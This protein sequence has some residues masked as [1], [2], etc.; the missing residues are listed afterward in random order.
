MTSLRS[1]VVLSLPIN[2]SKTSLFASSNSLW[3]CSERIVNNSS[4]CESLSHSIPV[5]VVFIFLI[6]VLNVSLSIISLKSFRKLMVGSV[7]ITPLG[8]SIISHPKLFNCVKNGFSTKV[9]SLISIPL[10]L[11]SYFAGKKILHKSL[12]KQF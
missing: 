1:T 3:G 11:Y 9:Y 5:S 10:N 4:I 7:G 6:Q 12:L 2:S 8:C